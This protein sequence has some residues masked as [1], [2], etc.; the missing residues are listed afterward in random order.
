MN[1][2]EQELKRLFDHASRLTD[3]NYIGRAC[4]GKVNNNLRAKIEFVSCNV[5]DRYDGIR[6]MLINRNDGEIDRNTL[7]FKDVLGRKQVGNT[8]FKDGVD[9]HLWSY[10]GALEWY[11]YKPTG[12]D[13]RKLAETIN[14]YLGIFQETENQ[15]QI[16]ETDALSMR[17]Y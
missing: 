14:L 15:Q 1:Q 8:N 4:Y 17:Q 10:N 13:L 9:P 12:E 16:T 11:V 2:F 3:I 6:V 7:L 5:I